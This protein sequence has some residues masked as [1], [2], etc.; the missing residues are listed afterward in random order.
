MVSL[1]T[2]TRY[3]MYSCWLP[4]SVG[5]SA[6]GDVTCTSVAGSKTPS[7]STIGVR[8]LSAYRSPA[9]TVETAVYSALTSRSKVRWL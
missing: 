3:F 6:S 4:R 7:A 5:P 8:L 9:T 2:S 1:S